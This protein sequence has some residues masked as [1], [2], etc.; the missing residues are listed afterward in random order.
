VILG[1]LVLCIEGGVGESKGG[2]TVSC[3][4]LVGM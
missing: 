2:H 3:R 4:L 1:L